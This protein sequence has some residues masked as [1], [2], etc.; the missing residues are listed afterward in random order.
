[1]SKKNA[2]LILFLSNFSLLFG[3]RY[4]M[5]ESIIIDV[6]DNEIRGFVEY[7]DWLISPE[8]IYFT[9]HL[10]DV[11]QSGSVENIKSFTIS[12]DKIY[13]KFFALRNQYI[14]YIGKGDDRHSV[15]GSI[16]YEFGHEFESENID[17]F[18]EVVFESD[19]IQLLQLRDKYE[20]LRLFLSVNGN[21]KELKSYRYIT[22]NNASSTSRFEVV[23]TEYK[24]DLEEVLGS[25]FFD[26]KSPLDYT[27]KAIT[28]LL[29]KYSKAKDKDFNE[30]LGH[31]KIRFSGLTGIGLNR[32]SFEDQTLSFKGKSYADKALLA[33]ATI[34]FRLNV[35][36]DFY[37]KSLDFYLTYHPQ[38][39]LLSYRLQYNQYFG[40][41]SKVKPKLILGV[42]DNFN[43]YGGL[44]I[45]W[46]RQLALDFTFMPKAGGDIF[47]K[48]SSLQTN[49]IYTIGN[50][51]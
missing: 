11:R 25:D 27:V 24:K 30:K 28:A 45:S 42:G 13:R 47:Q 12:S 20:E 1:M 37:N 9:E 6:N 32:L 49:L 26:S 34:G 29:R 33:T 10:N 14:S 44:G 3:Q 2:L 41:V 21:I 38:V 18:A 7:Q 50:N 35:P 46:K 16:T 17:A 8:Y 31:A 15:S 5:L 40:A 39:E 43:L 22:Y 4:P 36:G 51:N 48:V 19:Q 23:N